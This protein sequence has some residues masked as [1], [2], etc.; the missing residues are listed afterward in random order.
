MIV[1]LQP[2]DP[3]LCNLPIVSSALGLPF[4]VLWQE[5]WAFMAPLYYL[6]P[7]RTLMSGP[8]GEWTEKKK[9]DGSCPALWSR[10]T[11]TWR[12]SFLLSRPLR[13]LRE[14]AP[15]CCCCWSCFPWPTGGC[16]WS[17]LH[18][19]DAHFWS[20]SCFEFR[21]GGH[22]RKKMVN[23]PLVLWCFEAWSSSPIHLLLF[24]FQSPQ[25]ATPCILSRIYGCIQWETQG[26]V[27]LLH[28]TPNRNPIP[29][30]KLFSIYLC[31][32]IYSRFLVDSI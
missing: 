16:S 11:S 24:I 26:R 2:Q 23:S 17:S 5:R 32:Y 18:P 12:G 13:P 20:G 3:P 9:N 31:L 10:R 29:I 27:C 19:S 1:G 28:L 14:S 4:L 25:I 15:P 7:V 30:F 6:L 21:Q 8:S 22:Q